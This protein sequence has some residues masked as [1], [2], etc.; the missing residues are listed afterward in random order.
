M[1]WGRHWRGGILA[2]A[3]TAVLAGCSSDDGVSGASDS[4]TGSGPGVELTN[5]STA[6][7][8]DGG[9]ITIVGG[10]ALSAS[11]EAAMNKWA[12][13]V[14]ARDEA[15]LVRKCWT[16]PASY[17]QDRYLAP[18]SAKMNEL[19]A[20][21]SEGTQ[22]GPLWESSVGDAMVTWAEEKSPYACPRI[23]FAGQDEFP[24]DYVAYRAER[25]IRRE[26]GKPVNAGDTESSYPVEC[27]FVRGTIT[28]IDRADPD[29]IRVTKTAESKWTVTAGPVTLKMHVEP[30]EPCIESAS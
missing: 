23:T 11:G 8:A 7:D 30:G 27:S 29:D 14:A 25:Y 21:G 22:A 4:E 2:V 24:D 18:G 15:A 28:D 12:A 13:D 10:Q 1:T 3:A 9:P 20:V 6:P 17:I 16:L 5:A 19:F 26:Q